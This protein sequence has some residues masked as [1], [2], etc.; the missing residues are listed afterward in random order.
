[1]QGWKWVPV[2]IRSM[3]CLIGITWAGGLLV[4]EVRTLVVLAIR[5]PLPASSCLWACASD[6]AGGQMGSAGLAGEWG[7]HITKRKG[8]GRVNAGESDHRPSTVIIDLQPSTYFP[9]VC[10]GSH[11][12]WHGRL[13]AC[14]L[15]SL[16]ARV[17]AP[18]ENT[19]LCGVG[20]YVVVNVWRRSKGFPSSLFASLQSLYGCNHQQKL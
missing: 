19:W 17:P 12:W 2:L 18:S 6:R 7:H 8:V 4:S 1:M 15:C 3:L 11:G 16:R 20:F 14:G 5:P 13:A 9:A 10:G